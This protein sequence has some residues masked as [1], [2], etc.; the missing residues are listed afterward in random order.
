MNTYDAIIVGARCGG[1][2]LAMLLARAGHKVLL[3]DRMAFGSDIMSTHFL[4]RTGASHLQ[5]WGLLDQLRAIGTPAIAEL[6]FHIDDL[7]L[8]GQ[9]PA[10]HGVET[11]FTPRRFY[12]DKI[13]VDAAIAAGVEARDQFSVKE[14]VFE[15]DRVVGIRGASKGGET[16][17]ERAKVVIGADGVSSKVAQEVADGIGERGKDE[18]RHL[19]MPRIFTLTT[20]E[21]ELQQLVPLP[22]RDRDFRDG[23]DEI[24][25]AT[26][27]EVLWLCR[28][29]VQQ[30]GL[31]LR[32]VLVCQLR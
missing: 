5:N 1:A 28:E 18:E 32:P 16:V 19:P 10:Y 27:H 22:V 6:N 13:Q 8:K 3:L 20:L 26:A 23:A 7:H 31:E 12:L 4:K 14:L 2:P 21:E 25:H 29:H 30:H 11:D 15:N 17:V 24:R 9:A